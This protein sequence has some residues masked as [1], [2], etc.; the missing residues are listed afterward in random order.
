M[1]Q[2]Y[3]PYVFKDGRFLGAFEAMY[4][5]GASGSFDAWLQDDV[6]A[7]PVLEALSGVQAS[8][9][10]DLGCGKGALTDAIRQQTGAD[11]V[12]GIDCSPTAVRI[13]K[14]RYEGIKFQVADIP[15]AIRRWGSQDLIVASEVLSYIPTWREVVGDMLAASKLV[16]VGLFI[17]DNPNG[18]VPSHQALVEALTLHGS[19]IKEVDLGH[20][21]LVYLVQS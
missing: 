12:R 16:C 4:R 8:R 19:I 21:R 18:Y 7:H 1:T 11:S 3:H 20:S 10:L 9:V 6:S 13:A 2:P 17:P 14:D 5:D 15:R